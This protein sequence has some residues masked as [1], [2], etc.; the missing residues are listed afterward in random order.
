[1]GNPHRQNIQRPAGRGVASALFVYRGYGRNDGAKDGLTS[2]RG[3]T[4]PTERRGSVRGALNCRMS[5]ALVG[6]FPTYFG[7][8]VER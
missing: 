1:M 7:F 2:Q 5:M 4:T 8:V 6:A 3:A